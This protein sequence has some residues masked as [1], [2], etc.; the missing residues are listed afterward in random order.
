MPSSNAARL[1][2]KD[3]QNKKKRALPRRIV[4]GLHV[5]ALQSFFVML[6]LFFVM[7]FFCY[8]L[9]CY[10]LLMFSQL[11]ASPPFV[12]VLVGDDPALPCCH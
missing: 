5:A 1:L 12:N 3:E 7:L 11:V 10:F 9:L 2:R 8:F 6:F 4:I